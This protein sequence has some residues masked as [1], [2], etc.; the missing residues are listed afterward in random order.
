MITAVTAIREATEKGGTP[1]PALSTLSNVRNQLQLFSATN[2]VHGASGDF[3]I[4]PETGDRVHDDAYPLQPNRL[5]SPI[6]TSQEPTPH[7]TP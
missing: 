5:P 4:H 3:N 1:N 2:I 7:S 6:P